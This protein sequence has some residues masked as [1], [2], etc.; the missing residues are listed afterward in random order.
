MSW[1]NIIQHDKLGK[2]LVRGVYDDD[3][4]INLS[5]SVQL[6]NYLASFVYNSK[7][8]STDKKINQLLDEAYS[9][10]GRDIDTTKPREDGFKL[11]ETDLYG[12]V[13][14]TKDGDEFTLTVYDNEKFEIGDNPYL[15]AS[16]TLT[17]ENF[18]MA[19]PS[20]IESYLKF[21]TF[22]EEPS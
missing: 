15:V 19:E 13:L 11:V 17:K 10:F 2:V 9:Q 16:V 3:K 4:N 22:E 7:Y 12:L 14:L 8:P 18:E 5:L 21:S 1:A 20:V 6:T